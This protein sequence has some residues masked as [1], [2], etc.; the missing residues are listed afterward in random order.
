MGG[1]SPYSEALAPYT[2]ESRKRAA[3]TGAC[4]P[5]SKVA[6]TGEEDAHD[7]QFEE[8]MTPSWAG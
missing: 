8:E 7:E 4:E 2:V 3:S 6:R 5:G 1:A